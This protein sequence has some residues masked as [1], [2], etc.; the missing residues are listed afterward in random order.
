[1]KLK[2]QEEQKS[3]IRYTD[4]EKATKKS[5]SLAISPRN[6]SLNDEII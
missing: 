1:M 3:F 2:K 6:Y 5:A 4:L